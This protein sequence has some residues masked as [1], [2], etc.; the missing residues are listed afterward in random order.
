MMSYYLMTR[1]G[2]E[3]QIPY[4]KLMHT[5]NGE[6]NSVATQVKTTFRGSDLICPAIPPLHKHC[7]S[8]SCPPFLEQGPKCRSEVGYCQEGEKECHRQGWQ[9]CQVYMKDQ[10]GQRGS[11][12]PS[13]P[14]CIFNPLPELSSWWVDYCLPGVCKYRG[15]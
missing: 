3:T 13:A 6:L 7:S 10:Q 4:L 14:G 8:H 5:R 12:H 2:Q 9:T 15:K 11:E 1:N